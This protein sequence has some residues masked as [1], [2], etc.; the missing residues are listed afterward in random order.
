MTLT[1][2]FPAFVVRSTFTKDTDVF[3]LDYCGEL[4]VVL[5]YLGA[6]SQPFHFDDAVTAAFFRADLE[7]ELRQEGW[8]LYVPE[9]DAS[10]HA[11]QS[12]HQTF[13]MLR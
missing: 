12:H 8:M 5:T 11:D 1:T 13:D 10:G 3:I 7:R 2:Q 4:D 9:D 6:G